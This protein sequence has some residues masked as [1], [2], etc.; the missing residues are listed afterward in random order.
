MKSNQFDY[1]YS[2]PVRKIVPWTRTT[3]NGP[4]VPNERND[5]AVRAAMTVSGK[6]YK[7]AHAWAARMGRKPRRGT[8]TYKIVGCLNAGRILGTKVSKVPHITPSKK[9]SIGVFLRENPT[10]TFYCLVSRHA[11]AIV[12]GKCIDTWGQPL[13]CRIT[14]A[15][16]VGEYQKKEKVAKKK[17]VKKAVKKIGVK[18]KATKAMARRT[19][20]KRKLTKKFKDMGLNGFPFT[21]TQMMKMIDGDVKVYGDIVWLITNDATLVPAKS[22][23]PRKHYT[24]K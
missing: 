20:V 3:Y 15:W 24:I 4:Q 5:C 14:H 17:T 1:P 16:A 19:R 8:P 2:R 21:P 6:T 9:Q 11:F 23:S 10:G 22:A 7:E 18:K 12:D 13:G